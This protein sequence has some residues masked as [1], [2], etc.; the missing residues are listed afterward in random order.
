MNILIRWV[1]FYAESLTGGLF[2]WLGLYILSRG[3]PLDRGAEKRRWW[4]HGTFAAGLSF[5]LTAWFIFGIAL[6]SIVVDQD[7][8]VLW[9]RLTWWSVPLA[10]VLWLRAVWLIPAKGEPAEL[11]DRERWVLWG[12]LTAAALLA[13][14]SFTA[15]TVFR[16]Q[17]VV[18]TAAAWTDYYHIPPNTP[19]YYLF[20]AF[21]LLILFSTAL[22]LYRRYRSTPP[23]SLAQ[24]EFRLLTWGT[25]LFIVGATIGVAGSLLGQNAWQEH[26]GY[27]I[28]TVGILFLGRGVLRYNA[29]IDQQIIQQDFGRSLRGALASSLF[30]LLIFNVTFAVTDNPLP[31]LVV[32]LLIYVPIFIT[33]PL[34]W[35]INL[36]DQWLLPA[37]QAQFMWRLT[38]IRQQVLTSPNKQEALQLALEQLRESMQE[39]QLGQV[40]QLIA[41]EVAA[42]FRHRGFKQD[43]VMAHSRLFDLRLVQQ[44]LKN[45]CREHN[46]ILSLLTEREKGHFLQQFL[47]QFVIQH[48]KPTAGQ[49]SLRADSE[50]VIE[51]MLIYKSYVEGKMRL[52]VIRE[53]EHE[54]GFRLAGSG[55]GGRVYA[56]HLQKARNRL[57]ELLWHQELQLSSFS[58]PQNIP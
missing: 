44:A 9:L 15:N 33:T 36:M 39:A 46:L 4:R 56:Q 41:E 10:L 30:F 53:I 1:T 47:E 43:T 26:I 42:I 23:G 22:S 27:A 40:Q 45:Y 29:L 17:D 5:V 3:F 8:Y 21:L 54:T 58:H 20:I 19:P 34:R 24:R 35:F 18:A 14:L 7:E 55:T 50:Q 37:W 25:L 11:S 49:E 52:E 57:A 2:L 32:P 31:P 6:R 51:Y 12:G 48:L 13:F 38:E 28:A 16:Y